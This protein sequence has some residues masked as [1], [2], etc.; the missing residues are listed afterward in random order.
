MEA[1]K[2]YEYNGINLEQL[3]KIMDPEADSAVVS[4]YNSKA[5]DQDRNELKAMAQNDSF[6]PENLPPALR[7]FVENEL[8]KKFTEDDI[9]QFELAREVW[10]ENGIQF[11]FILFFRALPYTYMAEKPAN[12]LRLTQLL[13]T[14]PMRRV[15]ETA[16][17]VFD[18]M[19]KDWWQPENRGILT[20]LKVRIM[21]AAMRYN[22]IFNFEKSTNKDLNPNDTS[23]NYTWGNPISQEDLIAT[24]QCF[25]L[26]YFKGM[27]MLGQPLNEEQKNAWFY[28]WKAIGR[29]MGVQENL[30]LPSV[31]QAWGL[32]KTIYNHLFDFEDHTSG[33]LLAKALVTCLSTFLLSTRFILIIMKKMLFDEN[34]PDLF[35][36]VLG[37]SFGQEY[38][39]L[40]RKSRGDE[41]PETVQEQEK[42]IFFDELSHFNEKVK[43]YNEDIKKDYP[44]TRGEQTENLVDLQV[45][46]FDEALK[47][48]DPNNPNQRG[49][50]SDIIKKVMNSM[51]GV[52][53][54]VLAR[55]FREGKQSGFRIPT[56]LREH[57]QL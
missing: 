29:I 20:A 52:I 57:W 49:L 6:A 18:V 31:D 27:E 36:Q 7:K 3:R 14:Q 38:P 10:K 42:Q 55:Y 9:K 51:G 44:Q 37:P 11:V 23:W 47:D 2:K 22:L 32:Q 4:L 12:V 15:F 16:Q 46:V 54:S 30:L 43:K 50:M 33:I 21:H 35:Y 40:F 24:N 45:N 13:V 28:T 26:E 53:I 39:D 34:H 48:L 1:P 17:F 8:S 25:S 56:D 41:D 19:D 5:F